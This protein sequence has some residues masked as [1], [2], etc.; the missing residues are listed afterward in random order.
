MHLTTEMYEAVRPETIAFPLRDQSDNLKTALGMLCRLENPK[1]K[2]MK[3]PRCVSLP[4]WKIV[5]H[6]LKQIHAPGILGEYEWLA[7]IAGSEELDVQDQINWAQNAAVAEAYDFLAEVYSGGF[8]YKPQEAP[9]EDPIVKDPGAYPLDNPTEILWMA[10]SMGLPVEDRKEIA[11]RMH[12]HYGDSDYLRNLML[13]IRCLMSIRLN[14][15]LAPHHAGNIARRCIQ[16]LSLLHKS[17]GQ[18]MEKS[19]LRILWHQ[20]G[21]DESDLPSIARGNGPF[22]SGFY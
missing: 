14:N 19:G 11:D 5:T 17:V 4:T 10:P 15:E 21:G 6:L 18:N 9:K 7:A 8:V 22:T 16:S 12:H 3:Q 2:T 13:D 20:C 1:I